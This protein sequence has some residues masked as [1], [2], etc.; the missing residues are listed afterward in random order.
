MSQKKPLT[1]HA[2]DERL[3]P[4]GVL[5]LESHHAPDFAM[6]WRTHPFVKLVYA[7]GGAGQLLLR[8]GT[9]EY[10]S[11]DLLIVPPETPN[12][13]VDR[14][15]DPASLYVLCLACERLSFAP[16]VLASL[17]AGKLPRS[18]LTERSIEGSFRR[19]LFHQRNVSEGSALAM[20]ADALGLLER[21]VAPAGGPAGE[22]EMARYVARLDTHF[23][24]AT[25]IDAE[26]A[27]LGMSR[28]RFTELFRRETGET[29]LRYV[30]GR[31]IE[32]ACRLLTRTEAPI[33]SV[34][35][36]CG[37][38]DLSTFYRHFKAVTETTPSEWRRSDR[39]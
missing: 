3:P 15:G 4:W 22:T 24:E 17:R 30:R 18:R 9:H 7:V 14:A 29:W 38:T 8:G 34:A 6:E 36:E 21:I 35:F 2:L 10:E 28:R 39:G 12:R 20:V 13:L 16:R 37:F 27:A 19:L 11:R 5:V 31:A 25:D 1:R 32:H 33:T 23:Y 26:A